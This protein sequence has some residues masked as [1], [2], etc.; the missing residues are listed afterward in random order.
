MGFYPVC[1]GDPSY[2]IGSPLFDKVIINLENGK[3][4]TITANN[5]SF[6]NKYIQSATL[7]GQPYTKSWFSHEEILNGG[8]FV[9]VMAE[10][11]NK[12]WG[13]DKK[14]R[15]TTETFEP[16]VTLPYAMTN[17]QHFLQSGK[18]ALVC[19]DD[20]AVIRYTTDGT[21]PTGQ[22]ALYERPIVLHKTTQVRFAAFKAGVSP[23]PPVSIEM[24]QLEFEQ[25][26]NYENRYEFIPGLKYKYYHAHVMDEF[27]LDQLTPLE[28]GVISRFTVDERK[29]EDYFG[30][31]F[32]G[33]LHIPH[34]GIYTISCRTNDGSTLFLDGKKF[35]TQGFRTVALRKGMYKIGQKYFQLGNKKFDYVYWQGPGIERQEIPPTALFHRK[36]SDAN[37]RY[38]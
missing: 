17:D 2:A 7:N 38:E 12:E 34:D 36:N 32:S 22:S 5:A 14:D 35:M 4:F 16:F 3:K 24:K 8:Q 23:S 11:P 37:I 27:E 1:P 26:T 13:H 6:K 19:P 9:F 31:D 18:L 25:L 20:E 28:E 29:R 30:Y 33:Y 21:Q 10:Q 15:P